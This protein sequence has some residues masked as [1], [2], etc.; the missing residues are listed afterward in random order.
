MDTWHITHSYTYKPVE[1]I[2]MSFMTR[3]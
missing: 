2:Q 1:K 3:N